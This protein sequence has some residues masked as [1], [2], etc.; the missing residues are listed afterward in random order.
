MERPFVEVPD[1]QKELEGPPNFN[2]R[3]WAIGLLI[4]A[5][6]VVAGLGSFMGPF[7]SQA[8]G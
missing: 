2:S 4:V 5:T 8:L 6:A 7:L 3:A 1:D